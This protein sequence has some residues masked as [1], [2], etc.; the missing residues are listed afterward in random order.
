MTFSRLHS[1]LE[2]IF[3]PAI[4]ARFPLE[5]TRV[6]RHAAEQ[7]CSHARDKVLRHRRFV[8][9]ADG[10]SGGWRGAP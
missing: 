3:A 8:T 7:L 9:G 4:H 5:G 1:A 6:F 2:S 10:R